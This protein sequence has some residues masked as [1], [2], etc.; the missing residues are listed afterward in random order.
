MKKMNFLS[1]VLGGKKVRKSLMI[2]SLLLLFGFGFNTANAQYVSEQE[3]VTLMVQEVLSIDK[4]MEVLVSTGSTTDV[5]KAEF[6]M[7][8]LKS[9]IDYIENG[10]TVRQAINMTIGV[11]GDSSI[12]PTMLDSQLASAKDGR[13][14]WLIDDII[15]MLTL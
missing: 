4:N 8:V 13:N 10:N 2:F 1:R 12:T 15:E 6:K 14:D 5:E 9:M 3:A 11:E 7:K